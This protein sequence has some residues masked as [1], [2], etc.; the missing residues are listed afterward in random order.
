MKALWD[1]LKKL[2]TE[3]IVT[4]AGRSGCPSPHYNPP[5]MAPVSGSR[6]GLDPWEQD[7]EAG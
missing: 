3:M 7:L 2:G 6:L 1:E 4:K 5:H